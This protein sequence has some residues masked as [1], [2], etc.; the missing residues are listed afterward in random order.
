MRAF[1]LVAAAVL[2]AGQAGAAIV[3]YKF[4][5]GNLIQEYI[6]VDGSISDLEGE[7][8]SYGYSY[9]E[10]TNYPQPGV[11]S[12]YTL[13]WYTFYL[14]TEK[15]PKGSFTA[16]ANYDQGRENNGVYI[17]QH[18]VLLNWSVSFDKNWIPTSWSIHEWAEYDFRDF[19]DFDVSEAILDFETV[20]YGDDPEN[21]EW[22]STIPRPYVPKGSVGGF[23]YTDGAVYNPGRF[24]IDGLPAPVPLPAAAPLLLAG[25][26]ALWA[27]SRRRRSQGV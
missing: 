2:M 14:D 7:Q 9:I 11:P 22:W 10:E 19:T 24:T 20:I 13:P 6:R 26:A 15:A 17:K 18:A 21:S 27:I 5:P 3:T 8:P 12:G 25:T 4:Y 1:A 23:R 16:A